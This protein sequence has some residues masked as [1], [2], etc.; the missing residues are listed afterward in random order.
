VHD[1]DHTILANIDRPDISWEEHKKY[2][3]HLKSRFPDKTFS[4][5]GIKGL[6]GQTRQTWQYLLREA[7]QL[8]LRL[9]FY[10]WIIIPNSPAVYDPEYMKKF[11]IRTRQIKINK[12]SMISSSFS[13]NELDLAYFNFTQLTYKMLSWFE[14][15][16]EEFDQ[17][18]KD[19]PLI[20]EK[21]H[22][23]TMLLSLYNTGSVS[24]QVAN[25]ILREVFAD[26]KL[27]VKYDNRWKEFLTDS[28][29]VHRGYHSAGIA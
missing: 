8:N 23:T 3:R 12:H 13:F 10:T 26:H 18:N 11:N 16:L 17:F 21:K 22:F 9:E 2:I 5:E 27:S 20:W 15:T 28:R 6:P 29:V 14:V 1:I 19:I 4:L 7:Y 25:Q 24:P